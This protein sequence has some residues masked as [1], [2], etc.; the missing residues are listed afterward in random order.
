MG[1]GSPHRWERG[2]S[3]G[4]AIRSNGSALGSPYESLGWA[5][6]DAGIAKGKSPPSPNQSLHDNC[7][8][9]LN[10]HYASGYAFPHPD[11][12]LF[13]DHSVG[14]HDLG[15]VLEMIEPLPLGDGVSNWKELG[16]ITSSPNKMSY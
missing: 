6:D 16:G 4:A 5:S 2:N 3:V 12:Q 7:S 10:N 1:H 8:R 13:A 14:S 9:I 15:R 11:A